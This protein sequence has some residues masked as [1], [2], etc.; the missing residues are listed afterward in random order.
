MRQHPYVFLT[1]H[2]VTKAAAEGRLREQ[3]YSL[4]KRTG[5]TVVIKAE[6]FFQ[7]KGNAV[8]L[9]QS[10]RGKGLYK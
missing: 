2:R 5:A 10:S 3:V 7:T 9:Q 1:F 4:Q 8:A 6:S